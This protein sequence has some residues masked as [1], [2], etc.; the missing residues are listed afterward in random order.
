MTNRELYSNRLHYSIVL[1]ITSGCSLL[2]FIP[3]TIFFL[4]HTLDNETKL[5]YISLIIVTSVTISSTM[6]IIISLYMTQYYRRIL[7]R[8]N[9]VHVLLPL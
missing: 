9:R 3:V 8:T 6:L 2:I 5:N 4:I 1:S 7:A